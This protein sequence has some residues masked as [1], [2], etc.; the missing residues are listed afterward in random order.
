MQIQPLDDPGSWQAMLTPVDAA[1]IGFFIKQGYSPELLFWLFIDHLRQQVGPDTYQ[2]YTND[3]TNLDD[4]QQF[5]T[6]WKY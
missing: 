1:T 5:E 2:E 4:V 6:L 3:P